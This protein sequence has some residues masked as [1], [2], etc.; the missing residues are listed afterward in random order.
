M[1][2]AISCPSCG[3]KG[4]AHA[5]ALLGHSVRCPHCRRKFVPRLNQTDKPAPKRLPAE[6]ETSELAQLE[7]EEVPTLRKSEETT[8]LPNVTQHRRGT[9]LMLLAFGAVVGALVVL[10]VLYILGIF[11]SR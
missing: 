2:V 7:T 1:P 4:R 5:L 8:V 3:K 10:L 6:Q 9:A 11:P